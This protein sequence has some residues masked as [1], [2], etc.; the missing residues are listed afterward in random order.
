VRF[1]VLIVGGYV[2]LQ[3]VDRFMPGGRLPVL[4]TPEALRSIPAPA[5]V[6][7]PQEPARDP[8]RPRIKVYN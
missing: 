7:P 4:P 3:M 2:A 8:A 5:P 6:A 1:F